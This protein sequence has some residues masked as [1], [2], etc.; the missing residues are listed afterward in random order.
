MSQPLIIGYIIRGYETVEEL[1]GSID[2]L[3]VVILLTLLLGA[4]FS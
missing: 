2:F 1:C 3:H 4:Y